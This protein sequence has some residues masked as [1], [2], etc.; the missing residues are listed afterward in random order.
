MEESSNTKKIAIIATLILLV[1][2]GAYFFFFRTPEPIELFDEFGNPTGAEVVGQDLINIS[3]QLEK[4]SL[5][6]N[7][8]KNQT[9]I[10]LIDFSITLPNEPVGKKNPFQGVNAPTGAQ[11]APSTAVSR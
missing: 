1:V 10:N 6:A 5:D 9:F 2:L 8:F 3:N 4:V 7:L 11:V